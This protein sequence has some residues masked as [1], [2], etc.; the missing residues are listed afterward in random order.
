MDE[1][2]IGIFLFVAISKFG[3]R[4]MPTTVYIKLLFYCRFRYKL[5]LLSP[6]TFNEKLQWLKIYDKNPEYIDDVDKFAVR[7]K[8]K[9]TI[10]EKY[11]I[12]LIDYYIHPEDIDYNRLPEQFVL[13]C[14]H[15]THCSIICKDKSKLNIQ[16]TNN[17][18]RKWLKHNY[19]Y[20]ARE[21]PYREVKPRI[22]CEEYIAN[23]KEGENFIDYKFLCFNGNVKLVMVHQDINNVNRS[24]T[25]DIYTPYWEKTKIKWGIPNSPN[26]LPKPECL[27]EC[28]HICR[29]LSQKRPHVRV[30]LYIVK[31]KIYFGEL[32]YYSAAGFKPFD[33]FADDRMLGELINIEGINACKK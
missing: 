19:Y 28:L 18:L 30:D 4:W 14:T 8:V 31:N 33:N 27:E 12:P 6:K 29:I 1:K 25:L 2:K 15:G 7:E 5:N 26:I 10:G 9:N 13:K 17:M 16:E 23:D 3:S 32:T 24:H 21:W 11:L 20:D 22:I